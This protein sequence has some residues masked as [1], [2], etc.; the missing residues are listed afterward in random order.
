[1]VGF[2]SFVVVRKI[3]TKFSSIYR[4][5]ALAGNGIVICGR[6]E[7]QLTLTKYNLYTRGELGTANL[8]SQPDGMI[9]VTLDGRQC[10]ALSYQ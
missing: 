2:S 7:E 6:R 3:F 5:T 9:N 1:M 8:D 4:M 10:L